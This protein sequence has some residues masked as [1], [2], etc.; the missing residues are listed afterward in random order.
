MMVANKIWEL[1]GGQLVASEPDF[2]FSLVLF[3]WLHFIG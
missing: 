1:S 3:K 2:C